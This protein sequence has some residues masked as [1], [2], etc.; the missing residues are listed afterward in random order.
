[1]LDPLK[2]NNQVNQFLSFLEIKDKKN[3]SEEISS[4]LSTNYEGNREVL[5]D[6][7][8]IQMFVDGRLNRRIKINEIIDTDRIVK[9][10]GASIIDINHH[11]FISNSAALNE[12]DIHSKSDGANKSNRRSGGVSSNNNNNNNNNG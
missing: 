5:H 11:A 12:L 4:F 9:F 3:L 6:K 10:D 8:S 1:M 7:G 2:L